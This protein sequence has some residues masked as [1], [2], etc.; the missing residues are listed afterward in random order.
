MTKE[1]IFEKIHFYSEED[2]LLVFYDDD[3]LFNVPFDD[4]EIGEDFLRCSELVHELVENSSFY[5]QLLL[6]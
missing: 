3:L 6:K 1:E 5:R 4:N 2:G